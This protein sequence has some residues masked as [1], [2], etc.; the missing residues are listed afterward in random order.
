MGADFA[1]ESQGGAAPAGWHVDAS[2]AAR[3]VQHTRLWL[4]V[5]ASACG[6]KLIISKQRVVAAACDIWQAVQARQLCEGCKAVPQMV[7]DSTVSRAGGA[8]VWG[9]GA[10]R[11]A[12]G[13]AAPLRARSCTGCMVAAV[14]AV[15]AVIIFST[16]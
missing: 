13:A 9:A 11:A 16:V 5:S 8:A 4:P 12:Q 3:F 6:I 1:A 15:D 10:A 14:A 7:A 2:S